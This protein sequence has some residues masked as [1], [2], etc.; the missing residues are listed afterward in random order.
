[1]HAVFVLP[2]FFPYKGG[3][4]NSMLA[5]AK[6]LV[7]RGHRMTVYTTTA[8]DLESLWL[9]GF[10]TYPAGELNVDGVTIRRFPVSYNKLAL[11]ATRFA[12]LLPYWRWKAQFWR[13]GFHVPGLRAALHAAPADVFHVGPLPYNNLMYAGI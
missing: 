4:E 3:Y 12:G 8:E 7:T 5:I 2:R 1:M 11:R 13:P 10:K 9:P 6:C